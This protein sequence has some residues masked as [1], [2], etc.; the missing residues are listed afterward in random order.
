[1]LRP[2]RGIVHAPSQV[3]IHT[4]SPS[5]VRPCREVFTQALPSSPSQATALDIITPITFTTATLTGATEVQ[6]AELGA[7]AGHVKIRR[8]AALVPNI[9]YLSDSNISLHETH[10]DRN[11]FVNRAII[12]GQLHDWMVGNQT[13]NVAFMM[14]NG[15]DGLEVPILAYAADNDT[16]HFHIQ[17]HPPSPASNNLTARN[18]DYSSHVPFF[19]ANGDGIKLSMQNAIDRKS[20]PASQDDATGMFKAVVNDWF[21]NRQDATYVGYEEVFTDVLCYVSCPT[22]GLFPHDTD[23]LQILEARGFG[24]NSETNMCF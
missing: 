7:D 4:I 10:A 21:Y 5:L 20:P 14:Y 18:S 8:A 2:S 16:L 6:T 23:F 19:A 9:T 12:S 11:N 3:L 17:Y 1:M 22:L 15:G 13:T 24:L